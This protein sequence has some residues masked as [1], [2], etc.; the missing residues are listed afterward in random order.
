MTIS[1]VPNF[2]ALGH[3]WSL[4]GHGAIG[5]Q[6][7]WI[8]EYIR[9]YFPAFMKM[10]QALNGAADTIYKRAFL[11][12]AARRKIEKELRAIVSEAEGTEFSF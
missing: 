10:A 7:I 5:D 6:V 12:T 2:V 8:S 1:K 9:L 11:S 4:E 3:E